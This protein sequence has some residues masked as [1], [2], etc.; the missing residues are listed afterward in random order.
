MSARSEEMFK[1]RGRHQGCRT[2]PLVYSFC[3]PMAKPFARPGGLIPRMM[4][5]CCM[6]S[7][8]SNRHASYPLNHS[9]QRFRRQKIRSDNVDKKR[10]TLNPV[11]F[12]ANPLVRLGVCSG[13]PGPSGTDFKN[14]STTIT[15]VSYYGQGR[16][17][18][19]SFL[20]RRRELSHDRQTALEVPWHPPYLSAA[21]QLG[22]RLPG[23]MVR[24][25]PA[26]AAPATR[27][28]VW[29]TRGLAEQAVTAFLGR[30]VTAA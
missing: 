9:P 26:R 19:G 1:G 28:S 18:R 25:R 11:F 16:S 22:A 30:P 3:H 12:R 2:T 24:R 7:D 10:E 4:R 14:R 17:A 8:D 23:R 5:C 21:P 20:A 15:A 27:C 6:R 29:T 13:S